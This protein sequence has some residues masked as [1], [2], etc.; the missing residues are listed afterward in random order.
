MRPY[1]PGHLS[2]DI[3]A[4]SDIS[5]RWVR[6]TRVDGDS[7]QSTEVPLGEDQEIYMVRVVVGGVVLREDI[8]AAQ[9]WF[10]PQTLRLADG[11]GNDFKVEVA[12]VSDRFGPGSFRSLWIHV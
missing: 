2:Y 10:Y 3:D 1:A 5:L 6:R 11:A 8:V 12:Q 9:S 7:W 4:A